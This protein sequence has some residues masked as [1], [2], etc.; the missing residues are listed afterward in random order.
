MK[1]NAW[2]RRALQMVK[3]EW[4]NEK[5]INQ[6]RFPYSLYFCFAVKSVN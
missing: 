5:L 1:L 2:S 6:K 3:N 4:I